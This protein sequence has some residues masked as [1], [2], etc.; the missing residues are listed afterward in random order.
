MIGNQEGNDGFISL[1]LHLKGPDTVNTM[2][3]ETIAA[4]LEHGKVA[5]TLEKDIEEAKDQLAQ[6]EQLG[7]HLNNVT[8]QLLDEGVEKF[9]NSF[10][11]L[12]KTINEKQANLTTA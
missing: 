10:D 8:D 2:P 7:I 9:I 11:S 12:M 6:F 4:F 1:L 3:P 5:L